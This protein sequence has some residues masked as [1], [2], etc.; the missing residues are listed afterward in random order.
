MPKNVNP[1]KYG[2]LLIALGLP[3]GVA[4]IAIEALLAHFSIFPNEGLVGGAIVGGGFVA[5]IALINKF[6]KQGHLKWLLN[7]KAA[8]V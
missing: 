4:V 1:I 8:G 6:I 5:A 2:L 3:L 7:S